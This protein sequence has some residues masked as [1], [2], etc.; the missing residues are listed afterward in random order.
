[1]LQLAR[2]EQRCE[3][4]ALEARRRILREDAYFLLGI[5]AEYLRQES[6]G[7]L[8]SRASLI[9]GRFLLANRLNQRIDACRVF[10]LIE[11]GVA[12]R[13][14]RGHRGAPHCEGKKHEGQKN[15]TF[16]G[17]RFPSGVLSRY[18]LTLQSAFALPKQVGQNAD[19]RRRVKWRLDRP[20]KSDAAKV[21]PR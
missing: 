7:R 12:I 18:T 8:W 1:V 5:V 19:A 20:E 17:A 13:A 14:T 16:H 10:R 4:S 15:P 11:C 3:I 9:T 21:P 6:D 2:S